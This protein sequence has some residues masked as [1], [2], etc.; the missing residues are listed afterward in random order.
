M[1]AS[2]SR[3]VR[4]TLL[5]LLIAVLL[6][7]GGLVWLAR[8]LPRWALER[9]LA[10]A[11]GARVELGEVVEL[12][13]RRLVLR[14]LRIEAIAA[15]PPVETLTV[16]EL[17]IEASSLRELAAGRF[18]RLDIRGLHAR[19]VPEPLVLSDD[20]LP[21]AAGELVLGPATI[22]VAAALGE[23][24]LVAEGTLRQVGSGADGR[25]AAGTLRFRSPELEIAPLLALAS[26]GEPPSITGRLTDLAGELEIGGATRI[27]ARAK[28]AELGREDLDLELPGLV[29]ELTIAAGRSELT[30][31]STNPRIRLGRPGS[32]RVDLGAAGIRAITTPSA[33]PGAFHFELFPQV[34][35]LTS[36]AISGDWNPGERRLL[37][38]DARLDGLRLEA[39]LGDR[40]VEGDAD[41]ELRGD[42]ERLTYA[43]TVRPVGLD[44][45]TPGGDRSVRLRTPGARLTVEGEAAFPADLAAGGGIGTR[46]LLAA[47]AGPLAANLEVSAASGGWGTIEVPAAA[48][49]LTARFD[50]R[51]VDGAAAEV[52]GHISLASAAGGRLTADGVLAFPGGDG[53]PTAEVVWRLPGAELERWLPLVDRLGLPRERV[54]DF[55]P[56]G[57]L[58]AN[59]RLRGPLSNPRLEATVTLEDL[60]A[61]GGDA[62]TVTTGAVEADLRVA[63]GGLRLR[64]LA[65]SGELTMPLLGSI[66][67]TLTGRGTSDLALATGRLDEAVIESPG[68]GRLRLAGDWRTAGGELLASGRIRAEDLGLAAWQQALGVDAAGLAL[69]GRLAAELA[70]EL[71]SGGAWQLSGPLC[72]DGAGFSSPFGARV[73]EGLSAAAEIRL[74]GAP[75]APITARTTGRGGAFLLLWDAFFGDFS[76][77]EADFEATAAAEFAEQEEAAEPSLWLHGSVEVPEGPRI[78]ATVERPAGGEPAYRLRLDDRDLAATHGRYLRQV[79]RQRFGEAELGGEVSALVRGARAVDGSW[80]VGGDLR[81]TDLGWTSTSGEIA[82]AGLDLILPLDL[83]FSGWDGPQ[84]ER[85]A[86]GSRRRSRLRFDRLALGGLE[87]PSTD[88]G[89]WVEGDALGIDEPIELDILGGRLI[90][91]RLTVRRLLA[92]GRTL[93]SSL[94]LEALSLEEIS[95]ALQIF[96]LEGTLD[97]TFPRMRLSADQLA[98]EGGGEIALFGGRVEVR[99]ISGEE[100]FTRFPKLTLSADLHDIDLGRFTRRID[101]GEMSGVLR[102]SITGCELFR[103]IPVRCR[104]SFETVHRPGVARTV[105]V[106]AINLLTILGTGAG[107]GFLDRGIR[108][109]F[110]RYTYDRLA[111]DVDLDQDVLLLRGGEQRGERELFLSGR[112]PFPIDVVNAQPGKTVSFQ[113]MLR[114]LKS[115]E[116]GDATRSPE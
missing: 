3:G 104:A 91:E 31:S 17:E 25:G 23:T 10:R 65:A 43:L 38:L 116:V 87:L 74:D 63:A 108:R 85:R 9:L 72:A 114:R 20:P 61:T 113:A 95:R 111:V 52:H 12:R 62:W 102:G 49:P 78:A 96:P 107:I 76:A 21:F 14:E 30:A 92:P 88:S 19:L 48:L 101:F 50:G 15:L 110:K 98:V 81:V 7:A 97:G 36:A 66:P 47:L 27:K 59:G 115:L 2:R 8:D 13:A 4:P 93:E 100:I 22:R 42:G 5:R 64:S 112:L 99:D 32:R 18:E 103:G 35:H 80:T 82:V 44:F 89:L 70:A 79:L 1:P 94:T 86:T 56:T 54:D 11:A 75:G 55:R 71:R 37:G 67:L 45:G 34:P 53:G 68:L 60:G 26:P 69:G 46:Q 41:L 109:F 33:E 84:S 39:L 106:K 29:A 24:G 105:D 40:G 6:I 51:L 83:R 73:L 58:A 77:V 57:R 16:G 90:L 28:R